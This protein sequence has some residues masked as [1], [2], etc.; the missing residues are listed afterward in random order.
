M[1]HESLTHG[2][3]FSSVLYGNLNLEGTRREEEAKKERRSG[4]EELAF[5]AAIDSALSS[6]YFL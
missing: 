6:V 5:Q 2:C 3:P 1:D 4:W